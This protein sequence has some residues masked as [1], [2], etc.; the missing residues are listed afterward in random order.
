MHSYK[1]KAFFEG[2]E[3]AGNS[4]DLALIDSQFEDQFIFANP[5]GSQ[6]VEKENFLAALPKRREFFK[7]LGHLS[8]RILSLDEIRLDD[9]YTMVKAKFLMQ[10]L[11]PSGQL[12]KTEVDSIYILFLKG[13]S[14][15]IVMQIEHE[16]L[17]QAM[18]IRGLL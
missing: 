8:T 3:Q 5:N 9:Q 6:V 4:M 17:Q 1:I 15:K 11:T 14:P 7:S 13:D 2:V 12:V 18:K 10:F 16:D